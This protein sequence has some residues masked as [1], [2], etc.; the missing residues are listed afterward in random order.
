[1]LLQCQKNFKKSKKSKKFF[2]LFDLKIK[3]KSKKSIKSIILLYN[4]T[5]SHFQHKWQKE[6]VE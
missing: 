4:F 3:Q 1:M 5:T 6:I 2:S